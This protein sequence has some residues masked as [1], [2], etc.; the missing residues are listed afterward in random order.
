MAEW[1]MAGAAIVGALTGTY[2]ASKSAHASKR[3]NAIAK[4]QMVAATIEQNEQKKE[5]AVKRRELVDQQ[6]EGLDLS[7]HYRTSTRE[8]G[9][10]DSGLRGKLD[11][12]VL[13]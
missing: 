13:G 5:E 7:K 8:S 11:E 6:R 3:Q 12:D 2:S 4:E 10:K 9:I 1:V